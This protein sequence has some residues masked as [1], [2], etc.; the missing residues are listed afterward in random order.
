MRACC[1]FPDGGTTTTKEISVKQLR[2]DRITAIRVEKGLLIQQSSSTRE[3]A[4]YMA[5]K[6]VPV[7]V[8]QRVLTTPHRR[9][10]RDPGAIPLTWEEIVLA[11][12]PTYGFQ[13]GFKTTS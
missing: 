8:A 3:A 5:A 4:A 2:K 11:A 9:D 7:H 6:G 12:G 1:I 13:I 10:M